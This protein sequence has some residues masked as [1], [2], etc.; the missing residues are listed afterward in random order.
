MVDLAAAEAASLLA[1]EDAVVAGVQSFRAGL[2][3]SLTS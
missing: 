1:R 3:S 2:E